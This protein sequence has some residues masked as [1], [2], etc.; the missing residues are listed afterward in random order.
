MAALEIMTMMIANVDEII[1]NDKNDDFPGSADRPENSRLRNDRWQ[2]AQ[3]HTERWSGIFLCY[4]TDPALLM[5]M[6][7]HQ[8]KEVFNTTAA[9]AFQD[10]PEQQQQ[11]PR[12][13]KDVWSHIIILT[14]APPDPP[15]VAR[16]GLSSTCRAG[17]SPPRSS[18][19]PTCQRCCWSEWSLGKGV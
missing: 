2:V 1:L 4:S 10:I 16:P 8:V 14:Q 3:L 15:E 7:L 5:Y 19:S 9:Y 6:I 11:L 12:F 13:L 18:T 17:K